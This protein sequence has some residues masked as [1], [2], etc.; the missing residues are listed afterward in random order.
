MSMVCQRELCGG[1]VGYSICM[2]EKF[3]RHARASSAMCE[4]QIYQ[5]LL[6]GCTAFA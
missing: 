1:E 4:A 3:R 6:Q 5:R 2:W